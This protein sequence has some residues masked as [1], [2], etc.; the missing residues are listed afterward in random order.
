M[1][2]GG[3]QSVIAFSCAPNSEQAPGHSS[4]PVVTQ[5]FLTKV[6]GSQAGVGGWGVGKVGG[7]GGREDGSEG[8]IRVG[9]GMR[10]STM[11]YI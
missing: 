4:K 10:L 8:K 9:R 7:K 2:S 3:G 11:S 5:I 1:D 6:S